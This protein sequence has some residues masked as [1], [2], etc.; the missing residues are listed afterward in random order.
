MNIFSKEAVAIACLCL[1]FV[2]TN[3]TAQQSG[4]TF[5][6]R[7]A[8]CSNITF[9]VAEPIVRE[10][11]STLNVNIEI[12]GDLNV[13]FSIQGIYPSL[14]DDQGTSW[15]FAPSADFFNDKLFAPGVKKK[16]QYKFALAAGGKDATR[17]TFVLLNVGVVDRSKGYKTIAT[18]T[19]TIKDIPIS[20][21]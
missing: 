15:P 5:Q 4:T 6:P 14:I 12:E 7:T 2:A 11:A 19:F 17:A 1:S 9:R 18:C 16:K 3:L 10:S 13:V 20:Q 21:G 8:T